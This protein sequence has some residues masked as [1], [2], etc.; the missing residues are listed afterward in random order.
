VRHFHEKLSW[1]YTWTKRVLQQQAGLVK[2]AARRGARTASGASA[3]AA[4]Q[5]AVS[6][7]ATSGYWASKRISSPPWMMPDNQLYSAF[8]V[9]EEGT[10]SS[11]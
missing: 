7:A 3:S 5:A 11:F 9:E 8:L 4:Q 6:A 10:L 1:C 2:R